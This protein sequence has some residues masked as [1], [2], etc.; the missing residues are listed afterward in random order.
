MTVGSLEVHLRIVG[1]RS[2]KEKRRVIVPLAERLRRDLH[3][4]VGEVADND[5]WNVATIG[6]ACVAATEAQARHA[7]SVA[8]SVIDEGTEYEVQAMYESYF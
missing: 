6:V 1:A 7:V 8:K 2:L 3:L 5:L 4:A